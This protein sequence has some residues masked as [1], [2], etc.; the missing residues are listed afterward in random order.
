MQMFLCSVYITWSH[1]L[2]FPFINLTVTSQNKT[3]G[4]ILTEAQLFDQ[5]QKTFKQ[6]NKSAVRLSNSGLISLFSCRA[7]DDHTLSHTRRHTHTRALTQELEVF[8]CLN[9]AL[10]QRVF[11]F[12]S[13]IRE[14]E[15]LSGAAA[16]W[17]EKSSG[18]EA[19]AWSASGE[20][21][22]CVHSVCVCVCE[23]QRFECCQWFEDW[24]VYKCGCWT[25]SGC[26]VLCHMGHYGVV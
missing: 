19:K 8:R 5:K 24:R 13:K 25:T 16:M 14:A 26:F 20:F 1:K 3:F 15:Q 4:S 11:F 12:F 2:V 10:Y 17:T 7:F 6:Q 23:W 18:E 9:Q 21:T 22:I